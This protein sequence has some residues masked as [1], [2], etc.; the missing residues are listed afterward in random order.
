[1]EEQQKGRSLGPRQRRLFEWA[2]SVAKMFCYFVFVFCGSG[3]EP[4]KC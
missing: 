4:C 1:M 3:V 2:V